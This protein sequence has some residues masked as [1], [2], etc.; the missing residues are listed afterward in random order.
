MSRQIDL[1]A[2]GQ[3]RQHVE[4]DHPDAAG[5]LARSLAEVR[6]QFVRLGGHDVLRHFAQRRFDNRR[7][8][9]ADVSRS[10]TTPRICRNGPAVFS[11]AL[12]STSLHAQS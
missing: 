9:H 11:R 10:A 7:R 5:R 1:L 8:V 4:P 3:R 2:A 12:T 6:D